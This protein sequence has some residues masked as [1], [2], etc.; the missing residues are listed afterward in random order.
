[1]RVHAMPT[2]ARAVAFAAALVL[3]PSLH[4]RTVV[5][6]CPTAGALSPGELHR[7]WILDGWEYH[8]GEPAFS[9]RAKLARFYDWG[10]RDALLFDDFDPQRRAVRSV[11]AYA[12]I[13]QPIFRANRSAYHA[14]SDAPSVALGDG[15]LAASSLEFTARIETL[16]GKVT[17][18]ATRSDIVWRC[19]PAGWKII[20]EHNSSTTIPVAVAERVL[21]RAGRR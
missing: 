2:V 8:P 6:A 7:T 5:E 15:N 20:R 4:A 14:V 11:A 9:F 12:A 16:A 13:W 3:T 18:I 10:A 17:G 21:A 19:G 1:M